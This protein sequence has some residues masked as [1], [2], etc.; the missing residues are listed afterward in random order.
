[1]TYSAADNRY[2]SMPYRRVGRSGLKLPAISLGL[3]HNFGDDKRFDE[4]R[5]ILRRAF[6][7][8]VNHFDLANNYGPPD[9][10]AEINFG[11][12]LADDFKPYRD[13]LVI[14]TKAGY[15]MWPGPY[16][17]WGSRKYLIS[18]LDQ[19]LQRMGLDYVD[20]FYSHRPDPETPMEETMGALDYAVRSGKALY[21]GISSYTPE[22]TIEAA[23]I[24]KELGT[25]L[26]IHQPS[27]SMLNRWTENGTPNLYEALEQVGAG[28]I[29]FSPLAQGMLTD[30]YLNGIP[31]DSRAAKERFLS[32]A[33]ITDEK[34]DR[35]RG[36]NKI[37]AG[38]GQSLAQMA[39]AWILRDQPKGPP[40]TSAL[41]GASS[42]RQLED[43]LSAINNLE[44]TEEELAAIDEFAVE[45]DIN[46][47]Q[48][49]P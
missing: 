13:E 48:Q 5:A 17:E 1:M 27:Y 35:I 21:A 30:R 49:K 4:Q 12:H 40:V 36:L 33:A 8:G 25:P 38:R 2:E 16:G 14:S 11:R 18:S 23:R 7:L 32:E 24:L 44:F 3:W 31:A 10:T 34:L 45:S 46:L 20:I 29:A 22:Q 37:A 41:I 43:T 39:I 47:W 42:V 6:D 28:S 9:G 26:L 19:S 15:Y